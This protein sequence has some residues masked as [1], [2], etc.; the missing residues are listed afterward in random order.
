MGES[1]ITN[2]V[3]VALPTAELTDSEVVTL[4]R[5]VR[6]SVES[7]DAFLLEAEGV[8]GTAEVHERLIAHAQAVAEHYCQRI[9]AARDT[10]AIQPEREA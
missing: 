10:T 4:I 1:F 8:T 2:G 9:L 5:A 7:E 3:R 6:R